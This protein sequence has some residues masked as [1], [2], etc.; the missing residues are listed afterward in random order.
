[1]QGIV[2]EQ[3]SVLD[4]Q[5][6]EGISPR[7]FHASETLSYRTVDEHYSIWIS[8]FELYNE[9]VMDLLVKPSAMKKRK[10]LRVMQNSEST[11]IKDLVQIPVFDLKEAEDTIRFGYANRAT[12]KTDL[13]EASSRSHAILCIT[14][15]TIDE[16]E[17]EPTMSHMCKSIDAGGYG[18]LQLMP[19]HRYL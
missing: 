7:S 14:L 15:I 18:L 5:S 11:V 10:P 16:F 17:E 19:D 3:P 1:M 6:V 12:S 8:F 4:D 9:N 13:N 2:Q